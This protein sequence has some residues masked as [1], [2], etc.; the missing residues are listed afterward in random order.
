MMKKGDFVAV[1]YV[2]KIVDTGE[3]FDLTDELK[4]KDTDIQDV[5]IEDA[6]RQIFSR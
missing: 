5:P 1:S 2:G 4:A 3:V 6:T